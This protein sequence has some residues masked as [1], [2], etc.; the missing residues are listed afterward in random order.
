MTI[1]FRKKLIDFPPTRSG[2]ERLG[3]AEQRVMSAAIT[4]GHALTKRGTLGYTGEDLAIAI[5]NYHDMNVE[6]DAV[7]AEVSLRIGVTLRA[8]SMWVG[9]HWSDY[10]R[11]LCVNLI[12]FLTIWITLPGG[13]EP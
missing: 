9:A 2:R 12:P 6:A 5:S 13:T 10:N 3:R 4:A 8:G 11:R 7:H 1:L